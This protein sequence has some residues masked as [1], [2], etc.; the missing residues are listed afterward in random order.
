MP[1][2]APTYTFSIPS[3]HDRLRLDCRVY[4]PQQQTSPPPAKQKQQKQR[5]LQRQRGAIIAHPYAPLGGCFDDPV[6]GF[7]GGELLKA[8]LV[9]GTF[10]FRGAGDSGGRTSWTARPELADYA[11][12]YVFMLLYLHFLGGRGIGEGKGESDIRIVLGGYSYGSMIASHLPG[13]DAI[14]DLVRKSSPDTPIHEIYQIA[15][16][17]SLCLGDDQSTSRPSPTYRPATVEEMGQAADSIGR[18]AVSYLLVSP[19]LPPVNQFLTLFSKMSLDAGAQTSAQG[20]QISCP[21]PAAQLCAHET[22][23]IYGDQ[24]TFTSASKLEKWSAELA[25][26]PESR[27]QAVEIEG[28][29]HFWREHGVES[30]AREVIKDWVCQMA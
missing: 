5:H 4:L 11:S 29:G 25:H 12:F 3:I 8:G 16:K 2:P 21:K 20:R 9:V 10:N 6:V 18:A 23:A 15:D 7:V 28:A 27:F 1:L 17:L 19:L 30:Q 24:D 13:L 22:L 26:A 14:V